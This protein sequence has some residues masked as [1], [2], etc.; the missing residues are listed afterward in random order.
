MIELVTLLTFYYKCAA[1]AEEGLLTQGER[2]ACNSTY[3]EIKSA[4]VEETVPP[5]DPVLRSKQNVLA[6]QRF[7]SWEAEN[8][9]LVRELKQR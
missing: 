7:K 5:S 6:Y 9:D 8:A 1:L 4:F 3:Q 2:F